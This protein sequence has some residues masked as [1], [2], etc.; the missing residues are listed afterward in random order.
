M[1]KKGFPPGVHLKGGRNAAPVLAQ[2]AQE[3]YEPIIPIVLELRRQG[4]SLRAIGR[5]LDRR[6]IRTRHVSS[7]VY[8]GSDPDGEIIWNTTINR[9]GPAQ[10]RRVL[11]RGG[12]NRA[13]APTPSPAAAPRQIAPAPTGTTPP[14]AP[15][16]SAPPAAKPVT[17][18]TVTTLATS[19]PPA[20]AADIHVW[21][22]SQAAGPFTAAQVKTLFRNGIINPDTRCERHGHTGPLRKL[23]AELS[24][25]G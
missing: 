18:A 14:A 25:N 2:M 24:A 12:V 16:P 19:T 11:I 10:V 9:W 6:G 22:G 8:V 7:S 15:A 5:E 23:L 1:S 20:D 21:I 13:A 3:F 4:L 17:P